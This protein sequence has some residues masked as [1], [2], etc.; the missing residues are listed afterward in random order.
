MWK[1]SE[2]YLLLSFSDSTSYNMIRSVLGPG[3][4]TFNTVF[5][6]VPASRE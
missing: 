6:I 1:A 2:P 5:A 3:T 4:E